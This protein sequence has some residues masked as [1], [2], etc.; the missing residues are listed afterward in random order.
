MTRGR[1]QIVSE[2]RSCCL[3][4]T[5][6]VLRIPRPVV[7]VQPGALPKPATTGASW[8][9][10][11][12]EISPLEPRLKLNPR[13]GYQGV[14]GGGGALGRTWLGMALAGGAA[15]PPLISHRH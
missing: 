1:A 3:S 13:C 7:V 9:G 2:G 10:R 11:W 14:H 8:I 6:G 5:Y 12:F 4:H 15:M